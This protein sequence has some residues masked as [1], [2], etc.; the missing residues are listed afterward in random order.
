MNISWSNNNLDLVSIELSS[1]Q[2]LSDVLG[3]KVNISVG[4]PVS[5]DDVLSIITSPGSLSSFWKSHEG[6]TST[7]SCLWLGLS[8]S[9]EGSILE[10][11]LYAHGSSSN[12]KCVVT[13]LSSSLGSGRS[14]SL[15]LVRNATNS[16]ENITF[17]E[18]S[19]SHFTPFGSVSVH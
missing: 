8:C 5:T 14:H 13:T 2:I 1:V 18:G 7:V 10:V 6:E 17:S 12:V 9:T 19:G 15:S 11:A 3:G 4:F 16:V